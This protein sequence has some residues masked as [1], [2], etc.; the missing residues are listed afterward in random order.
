MVWRKKSNYS[1]AAPE[2]HDGRWRWMLF[3]LDFGMGLEMHVNTNYEG[4]PVEYNM[5]K[6][7]L[8]DEERMKLFREL[9][10]NK[11]AQDRF[12]KIMLDRKSVVKGKNV[13]VTG[14]GA[15]NNE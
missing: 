12:I 8:A 9:M 15:H 11:D 1:L 2:G 13:D 7:V 3:D 14:H 6:H 4:N 5:I 10:K